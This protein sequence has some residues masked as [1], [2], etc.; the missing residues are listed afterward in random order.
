MQVVQVVQV[1]GIPTGKRLTKGDI[2]NRKIG[3]PV[4][5][6]WVRVCRQFIAKIVRTADH[7]ITGTKNPARWLGL[8]AAVLRGEKTSYHAQ[9]CCKNI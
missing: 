3:S 4:K 6:V 8:V 5:V 2:V 9:E 1:N 7:A